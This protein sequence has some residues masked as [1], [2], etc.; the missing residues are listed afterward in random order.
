VVDDFPTMRRI[1]RSL[2]KELGFTN[3][4]EAEDVPETSWQVLEPTIRAPKSEIWVI[5]NPRHRGSPTDQRFIQTPPPRSRIVQ[6]NA[7]DNPWFPPELEEQRAHAQ[8]VMDD[9]LFRHVWEGD[10]YEQSDAQV[11]AHKYEVAEFEPNPRLWKGPYYGLDFGFAQD[12]TAGVK[13]WIHDRKL[14]IEYEAGKVGLELDDT[15]QY[16]L[17]RLPEVGKHTVRAD[18]ARPESI[19]YL[20]RYGLPRI[21]AVE[22]GK[23]SVEDGVAFIKSFDKVIIHPRCTQTL[24]EF[25]LYSYKTDRLSGDVLPVILDAN[26][27]YIDALRYA[28][29]P[30]MKAH[31]F[32][33]QRL[34]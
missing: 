8:R 3:V 25:R 34:L 6:L 21:E 13:C 27:H 10:Y 14:H 33:Y 29:E 12:P 32:D 19:S 1:V 4:E 22:K 20:A 15:A 18:N 16:L 9:A 2:L 5:W 7:P 11:F 31:V 30:I 28:L 23:G 24:Q 17:D 26:N